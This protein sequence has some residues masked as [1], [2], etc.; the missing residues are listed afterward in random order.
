MQNVVTYMEYEILLGFPQKIHES[1]RNS[2][3]KKSF[4]VEFNHLKVLIKNL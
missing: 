2:N 3:S 4:T 1:Q